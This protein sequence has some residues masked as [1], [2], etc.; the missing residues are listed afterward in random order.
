MTLT[1][2]TKLRPNEIVGPLDAAGKAAA[3]GQHGHHEI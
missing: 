3:A 1:R 2:E